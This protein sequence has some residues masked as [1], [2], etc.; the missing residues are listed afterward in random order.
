MLDFLFTK[1]PLTFMIQSFWRDEAFTALLAK[2][3]IWKII[4]LTAKDFS[5]PLYYI[6]IHFWMNIFGS[7]EI[8][9]RSFSLICFWATIYI[10]Y[11]FI[12]EILKIKKNLIIL[13]CL[14]L[15]VTNPLLIYYAFEA[16]MYTLLAFLSSLSIYS[17]LRDK[18]KLFFISNLLNFYTHYFS[19]FVF[20]LEAIYVF[21]IK[22]DKKKIFVKN[23]YFFLPLFFYMPW[24]IFL[25]LNHSLSTNFWIKKPEFKTI[26][27]VPF[28]LYTGYEREF[29]FYDKNIKYFNWF[30]LLILLITILYWK[31]IKKVKYFN[32]FF[33]WGI[34]LPLV[35]FVFSYFIKPLF[36]P[37][38]LIAFN[39]GLLL[40]L[41]IIFSN[42]PKKISLLLMILLIYLN[43]N[44]NAVQIKERKKNDLRKTILEIKTIA[45]KDDLVYVTDELDF[46][47]VQYY[48]DENRVYIYNREYKEIPKYVGKILIPET[49]IK[50]ILPSFPKKAFILYSSGKY[51]IQSQL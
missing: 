8:S 1:T 15:V 23:N 29:N 36:L 32:F 19:F 48:F 22:K 14:I 12:T 35:I 16:R 18:R 50:D 39:I 11:L 42:L 31:K 5:P 30:F 38:Y 28:Y 40:F 17:L 41:T 9:L 47:V 7:S 2:K 3:D 10:I 4:Y 37:R 43:F 20:L 46:H 24:I 51:E 33:L 13:L 45:S 34:F 27:Q 25:F 49:K 6:L 44:Y 26:T 21:Y